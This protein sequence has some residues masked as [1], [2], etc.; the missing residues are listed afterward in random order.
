MFLA[1]V[2]L[3]QVNQPSSSLDL[4]LHLEQIPLTRL[5][6]QEEPITVATLVTKITIG[7]SVHITH[8]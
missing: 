3:D 5:I 6:R 4:I 1:L 8:L 7:D 2:S